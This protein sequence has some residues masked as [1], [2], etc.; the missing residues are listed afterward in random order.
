MGYSNLNDMELD[1]LK[2]IGNVGTGH[3]ATSLSK[4]LNKKIGLNIPETK[5]I[6]IQ[7]FQKEIGGPETIVV[8]AYLP[9]EGDISGRTIFIFSKEAA[10]RL[11]DLMMMQEPGT[12]KVIDAMGESAFKEMAN[13]VM[14]SYLDSLSNM[15]SLKI[16]PGIPNSA[17]DM[18]QAIIDMLLIELGQVSDKVLFVKTVIDVEGQAIDGMFFIFFDP[19]SLEKIL[20]CLRQ[21]YGLT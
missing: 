5:L 18:A 16:L 21:K 11:I 1:A 7:Q 9:T 17:I 4:L 6:P 19:I 2:E 8:A 13:I 10:C 3:A 14:G 12:T 15:F 20:S